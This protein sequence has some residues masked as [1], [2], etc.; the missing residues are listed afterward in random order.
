MLGGELEM[1]T[2]TVHSEVRCDSIRIDGQGEKRVQ[3]N[4]DDMTM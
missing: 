2:E 4:E 1:T 3:D